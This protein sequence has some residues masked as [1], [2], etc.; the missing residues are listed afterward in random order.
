MAKIVNKTGIDGVGGSG[1][2]FG[3]IY[4]EPHALNSDESNGEEETDVESP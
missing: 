2:S 1:V 3:S 4:P